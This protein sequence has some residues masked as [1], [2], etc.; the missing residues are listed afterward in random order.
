MTLAL[1][2]VPPRAGLRGGADASEMLLA[3][4]DELTERYERSM[5]MLMG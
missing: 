5:Q 4:F 1:T 2:L 3:L